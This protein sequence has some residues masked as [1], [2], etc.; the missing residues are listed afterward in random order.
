MDVAGNMWTMRHV[1]RGEG[2]EVSSSPS[3]CRDDACD[4]CDM[5][6]KVA[7]VSFVKAHLFISQHEGQRRSLTTLLSST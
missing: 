4:F 6:L 3:I 1:H 7:S 5:E 2:R